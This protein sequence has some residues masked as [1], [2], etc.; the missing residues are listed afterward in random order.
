MEIVLKTQDKPPEKQQ[1]CEI[2][3]EISTLRQRS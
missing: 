3:I 1:D 2:E